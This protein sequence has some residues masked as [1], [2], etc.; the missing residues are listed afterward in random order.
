[1]TNLST[2]IFATSGSG[3]SHF[4]NQVAPKLVKTVL[5]MN[6]T[7][8]NKYLDRDLIVDGDE[9]IHE[10]IGWPDGEWWLTL[11]EPDLDSFV[12]NMLEIVLAKARSSFV[13]FGVFPRSDS[14]LRSALKNSGLDLNNVRLLRVSEARLQTNMASRASKEHGVKPTD[15]YR[16]Y[17]N[18][19]A[20]AAVLSKMSYDPIS[21]WASLTGEFLDWLRLFKSGERSVSWVESEK[22]S[23][24]DVYQQGRVVRSI[25]HPNGRPTI[26]LN[27]NIADVT[28]DVT[29][30]DS[31]RPSDYERWTYYTNKHRKVRFQ[32]LS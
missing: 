27:P 20:F 9:L 17:A 25:I 6:L 13:L 11:S 26:I 1:M 21:S 28:N 2:L 10:T 23:I 7:K 12:E 22:T 3:K 15:P 5:G 29:G 31:I 19:E 32:Y 4:V 16:S 8:A 14:M 30:I 18:Q 24:V